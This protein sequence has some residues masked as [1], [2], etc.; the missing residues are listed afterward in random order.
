MAQTD[1]ALLSAY[2]DALLAIAQGRSYT[3]NGR[4]LTRENAR[5]VRETIDWLERRIARSTNKTGGAGLI[6]FGGAQ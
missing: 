3:I 5:E 1:A 4:T 2:Q 6:S